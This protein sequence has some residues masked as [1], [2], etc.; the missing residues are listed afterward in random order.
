MR[1]GVKFL[2]IL[3]SFT[4][5]ALIVLTT[6]LNLTGCSCKCEEESNEYPF[7]NHIF[8]ESENLIIAKTGDQFFKDY[9]IFD[10]V[11]SKKIE[12]FYELRYK[13]NITDKPYFKGEI[14]IYTDSSGRIL[15]DKNIIGIP[16]CFS[17]E[18][19]CDFNIDEEK[20]KAIASDAGLDSGVK[21]WKTGILWND[22]YNKYL[23]HIISTSYEA[24]G[25]E[26][27][28]ARGK[29]IL[30]EPSNGKVLEINDWN[31]R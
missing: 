10:P 25:I 26:R 16:D 7:P 23:W 18:T 21:A 15:K 5:I 20:A 13:I 14:V 9:I 22:K 17:D 31:I 24:G 19:N 28:I 11:Y 27:Y 12:N 6:V 8:A 29:E 2:K 30:I 4:L 3:F 1:L